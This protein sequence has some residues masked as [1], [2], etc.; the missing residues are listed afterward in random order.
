[1]HSE[2]EAELSKRCPVMRRLIKAHGPCQLA[3]QKRP[4]YEALVSAVAHQQLHA[5][6]AEAILRRFRAL[7]PKSRFPKP[8]QVL[9]ARDEELRGCGFSTGKMLAIRDIAAKTLSG[10]IPGR[11]AALR[12]GDEEL[13]E[14]LV[15]VRGVGRWT[16]EMLLIF[17][18]GRPDVFPSDD[19]GV[20]NGWRV[21][22]GLEEMPKP[23]AFRELAERWQPHR[24][25]AAWYLWR[26][27]DAAKG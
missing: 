7:F 26:A 20:R 17:T 5:N 21:V 22:K 8:E 11:A 2:A 12:L 14:R 19:Y 15:A 18:L 13:I 25:L 6:A 23:K 24:T 3:A 16:V 27:A 1:M 4:P 10:Q 9:N